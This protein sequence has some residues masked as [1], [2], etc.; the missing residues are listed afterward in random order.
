M[1]GVKETDTCFLN[2]EGETPS[3]P[4]KTLTAP[5]KQADQ[6]ISDHTGVEEFCGHLRGTVGALR[7][8]YVNLEVR[9]A[10][11]REKP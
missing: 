11:G 5:S 10:P 2:R 6:S 7:V 9:V 3:L 1:L 4:A 8:L